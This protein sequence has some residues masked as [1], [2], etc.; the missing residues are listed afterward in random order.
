MEHEEDQEREQELYEVEIEV[1][2]EV[3]FS[4]QS[5]Y[6]LK[7]RKFITIMRLYKLFDSVERR[8]RER[9]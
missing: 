1:V 7:N 8:E 6:I 5:N 4:S 2:E 9:E 3:R